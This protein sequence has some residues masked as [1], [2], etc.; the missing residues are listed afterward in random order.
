MKKRIVVGISGASGVIYGIRLLSV[1]RDTAYETHL[2]LTEAAKQ[3]IGLETTYALKTVEALADIVHAN[4][5]QAA[6]PASG[7]FLTAGMIVIPC[8]V[9]TLSGIVHS[10]NDNLLTRSAD[11]TLKEQRKLVLV[12]RETPLHLGHLKLMLAAAEL[13]AVILPPVP[14]FYHQPE[15][16]QDI[17]DQTVGKTLDCFGIDHNLF[18]RWGES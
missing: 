9:K 12:V 3:N 14:A 4:E 8:T 1:L 17:V 11:V 5:N 13:G 16:I 7:S 2:I 10:Y 15:T 6:A 18:R